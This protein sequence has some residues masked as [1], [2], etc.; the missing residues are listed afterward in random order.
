MITFKAVTESSK[1]YAKHDARDPKELEKLNLTNEEN[2]IE[3]SENHGV[4]Q[5][6]HESNDRNATSNND[7]IHNQEG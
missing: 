5:P 3:K 4:N 1:A 7:E 6:I 2:A